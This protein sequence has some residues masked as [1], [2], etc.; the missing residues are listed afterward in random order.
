MPDTCLPPSFLVTWSF[1]NLPMAT[2]V[3]LASLSLWSLHGCP[4]ARAATCRSPAVLGARAGGMVDV[5]EPEVGYYL[6]GLVRGLGHLHQQQIVHG[7]LKLSGR[8]ECERRAVGDGAQ[9]RPHTQCPPVL[10]PGNFF[11]NKN[12]EVKIGDLG[13]A[14]RVGLGGHC[15]R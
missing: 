2:G 9:L 12:M 13:L 4:G 5:T 15:H 1:S 14:A 10:P 6:R 7:D 11:L 3:P 8:R